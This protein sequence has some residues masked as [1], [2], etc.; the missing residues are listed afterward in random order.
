MTKQSI[1]GRVAQLAR[2]NINAMLDSAEDPG[3]MI[4]QLIRDYRDNIAEAEQS[5]AQTI[6]NLRLMEDDHRE[7]V[8]AAGEWGNK[9][10]AASDKAEEFKRDG[11]TADAEKFDRL[12]RVA[13][14]KQIDAEQRA[15]QTEP[16]IRSQQ[17][18][19]DRLKDGLAKMKDKLGELQSKRDSLV[20]RQKTAQAQ[21]QVQEAMKSVS[22]L[23]PTS[24]IGRF[25]EK[26]RRQEAQ[27]RGAQ[28]LAD[29]SLDAQFEQLDDMSQEADVEARLAALKSGG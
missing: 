16:A 19:V 21:T 2:A 28:E 14:G 18:I 27:V 8:E 22:I 7:D 24:E 13:L 4:D 12:A 3:K 23:D 11:R 1:F 5:I 9:A 29:S 26:V 6:G 17:E 25:E 20:A 10:A 15:A